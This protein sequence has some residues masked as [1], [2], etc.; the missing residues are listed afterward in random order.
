MR[1]PKDIAIV[2]VGNSVEASEVDPPLSA[3]S[4]PRGYEFGRIGAQLLLE[5]AAQAASS[6]WVPRRIT[7]DTRLIVRAS[8]VGSLLSKV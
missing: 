6:V 2:C 1:V 7:L 5:R 4:V 8:T 3:V